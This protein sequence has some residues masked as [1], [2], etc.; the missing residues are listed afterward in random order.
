MATFV[1]QKLEPEI[2]GLTAK[3]TREF[4]LEAR[5]ELLR[6]N[7]DHKIAALLKKAQTATKSIESSTEALMLQLQPTRILLG[8][9]GGQIVAARQ[10]VAATR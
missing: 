4:K 9:D 6:F 3:L 2:A 1:E 8:I 7:R 10:V 5:R